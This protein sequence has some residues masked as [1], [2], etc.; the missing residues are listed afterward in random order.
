MFGCLAAPIDLASVEPKIPKEIDD[1][2]RDATTP[3]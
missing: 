2:E 3:H 1:E